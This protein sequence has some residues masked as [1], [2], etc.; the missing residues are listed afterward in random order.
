MDDDADESA[1]PA[2][3]G[4]DQ[5][6]AQV[7]EL[8]VDV[9][10]ARICAL[11]GRLAATT[12]RWLD[13]IAEFDRRHGWSGAGI[14]SCAH[15]LAWACSMS[16]GA[17]REHVR[18]A[19]TL[20]SL[21]LVHAAFAAGELSYSKVR[22]VT[23]VAGKVAED[24][25]VDLARTCTAS[26]L[27][28][29]V[30]GFRRYHP[31]RLHQELRRRAR[32]RVDDD[33]SVTISATLP[34]EEGAALLAALDMATDRLRRESRPTDPDAG[35]QPPG[36]PP[37]DPRRD[38][39][40]RD[41][42]PA[43]DPAARVAD[44]LAD[45]SPGASAP[46]TDRSDPASGA[47]VRAG[48]RLGDRE[49]AP[50]QVT[51][52]DALMALARN[53]LAGTPHDESGADRNLVVVHVD[54]SG[55]AAGAAGAADVARA[56]GGA[57]AAANGGPGSPPDPPADPQPDRTAVPAA[58]ACMVAGVGGISAETA[59]MLACDAVVLG[60]IRGVGGA[61][62]HHGRRR[63]MVSPAQR[64]ALQIRDGGCRYPSCA[65]TS[66]LDAHHV[67]HWAA[68]GRTD[69][70]NLVLLCR[71][72]HLAVHER[73]AMITVD[74]GS[75][76]GCPRFTFRRPDGAPLT[77]DLLTLSAPGEAEHDQIWSH[78]QA[79]DWDDPVAQAI[80]PLWAGEKVS[81]ADLVAT[82]FTYPH[83]PAPW[84]PDTGAGQDTDLDDD[85]WDE[86]WADPPAAAA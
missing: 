70:D 57:G 67:R 73:V 75:L 8:P 80:R 79:T 9:L 33:G 66:G 48:R 52:A 14:L 86:T 16:P 58:D 62:L 30:R 23:R 82:L 3:A 35:E 71:F 56:E 1:G 13:L 81:M 5:E 83:N 61:V 20:Q 55:L 10:G 50:P 36:D 78:L 39:G 34:A 59:A 45:P 40:S 84:S 27:Q 68:Q 4:A 65:R 21:P 74:P 31:D 54:A 44:F 11:A 77:G 19:R 28:R 53:F 15:W 42:E 37:D 43:D 69:L 63:R 51:P 12:S 18:V 22:E 7:D 85:R 41:A 49:P 60:I 25:L 64:R 17:A 29:A 2:A 38:G 72:H 24:H 32:W 46:G 76:P 6:S 26:Q 47:D